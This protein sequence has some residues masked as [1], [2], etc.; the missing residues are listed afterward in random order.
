MNIGKGGERNK[1]ERK[2]KKRGRKK[3]RQG[4]ERWLEEGESIT[5]KL[6]VSPRIDIYME[7]RLETGDGMSLGDFIPNTEH[8]VVVCRQCKTCMAPGGPK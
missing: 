3:Q 1:G 2:K 7:K 6:R 4:E 8:G 5:H